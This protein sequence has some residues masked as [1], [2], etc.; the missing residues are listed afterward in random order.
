MPVTCNFCLTK[1]NISLKAKYKDLC[2]KCN[3]DFEIAEEFEK[4]LED[5][6]VDVDVWQMQN[7]NGRTKVVLDD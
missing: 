2:K 7:P 3:S 4:K 6:E 1:F 5:E